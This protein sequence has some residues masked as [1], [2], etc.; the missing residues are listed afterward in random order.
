MPST[1]F[2]GVGDGTP[3]TFD[4]VCLVS[5]PSFARFGCGLQKYIQKNKKSGKNRLTT[6]FLCANINRLSQNSV[7]TMGV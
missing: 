7:P 2:L 6:T 3:S 4:K 5:P 1:V